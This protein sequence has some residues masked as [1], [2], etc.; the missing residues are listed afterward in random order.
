MFSRKI[1]NLEYY[2]SCHVLNFYTLKKWNLTC[3]ILFLLKGREKYYPKPGIAVCFFM[4]TC[5]GSN[6]FTWQ[7]V[8]FWKVCGWFCLCYSDVKS[9]H[10]LLFWQ[11]QLKRGVSI[12]KAAALLVVSFFTW[13]VALGS[14]DPNS[15]LTVAVKWHQFVLFSCGEDIGYS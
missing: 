6:L 4:L 11:K 7:G 1:P 10:I 5:W 8:A 13:R 12:H 15:K 9:F 2:A 14:F 3:E